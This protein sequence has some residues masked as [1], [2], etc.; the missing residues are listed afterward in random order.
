MNFVFYDLE[1]T[2][3]SPAFDQPLQFAAIHTDQN[4]VE[5]DRVNIRC[6]LAP[7]I[8]PSPQALLITN[9]SP[10]GFQNPDLPSWFEFAQKI[11][12][13]TEKWAPAIWTGYNSIRFDEE[14]L[15]QTFFQNLLPVVFATQYYG[16]QRFDLY[17][18]VQ[19]VYA[20]HPEIL[21][22][23]RDEEQ[24]PI[25]SL[26][27]LAAS[28]GFSAHNA[29]DALGDVEATVH[30]A[31]KIAQRAP[32]LW[33]ELL[34]NS[35]KNRVRSKLEGY[36]PFSSVARTQSGDL[37]A[38]TGC[39][40]GKSLQNSSQFAVFDIDAVDPAKFLNASESQISDAMAREAPIIRSV[41]INKAPVVLS[42]SDPN[43]EQLRRAETIASSPHFCRRVST[44][45]AERFDSGAPASDKPV[46]QKIF[47]GFYSSSD[48][49]QLTDFHQS[50]W[51]RRR[52]IIAELSD[53]RLRQLGRRLIAFYCPQAMSE[54]E[55]SGYKG[56]LRSKLIDS[57]TEDVAWRTLRQARIELEEL[58]QEEKVNPTW[59]EDLRRFYDTAYQDRS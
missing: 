5:I 31:Q 30:I 37:A 21:S 48:I 7:H 53:R 4:L 8:V 23:V 55:L 25:L 18:A 38:Y 1:T 59:L 24:R 20:T 57:A 14:F 46:E 11:A 34:T 26:S 32:I 52:Q 22:W 39:L 45:M 36:Q 56:Y 58:Q 6:Q 54:K 28:N 51:I 47:D 9:V 42:I 43:K 13:L 17:N 41:F 3:I 19:G 50:D 16:N 35:N 49:E 12:A 10:S 2:G 44:V 33:C 27:R 29:H 15:R 40:C